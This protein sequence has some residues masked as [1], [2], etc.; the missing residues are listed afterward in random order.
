MVFYHSL[1]SSRDSVQMGFIF[2]LLHCDKHLRLESQC[3]MD[4][5]GPGISKLLCY[6]LQNFKNELIHQSCVTSV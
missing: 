6:G 1:Q 3:G 2:M 4:H 5:E